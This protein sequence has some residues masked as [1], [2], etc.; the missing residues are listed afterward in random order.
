M[1]IFFHWRD[2][3][4]TE[5]ASDSSTKLDKRCNQ[6]DIFPHTSVKELAC[7]VKLQFYSFKISSRVLFAHN[8]SD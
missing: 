1:F 2:G 8:Y 3:M 7:S 5:I 6:R 4:D